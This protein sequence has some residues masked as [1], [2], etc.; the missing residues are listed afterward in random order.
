MSSAIVIAPPT[1]LG[2]GHRPAFAMPARPIRDLQSPR[3]GQILRRGESEEPIQR[4][5]PAGGPMKVRWLRGFAMAWLIGLPVAAAGDVPTARGVWGGARQGQTP[6]L[7]GAFEENV[8]QFAPDIRFV[9]RMPGHA[10]AIHSD[11]ESFS[12]WLQSGR[13]IDVSAIGGAFVSIR[14]IQIAAHPAV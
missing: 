8:G 10:L 2:T 9:A 5:Q 6:F 11:L 4:H 7:T 13:S 1:Y 3:D 14:V 12:L